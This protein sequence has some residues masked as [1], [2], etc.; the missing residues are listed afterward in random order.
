MA[1]LKSSNAESVKVRETTSTVSS[2]ASAI[3]ADQ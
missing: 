3:E 1:G 2:G